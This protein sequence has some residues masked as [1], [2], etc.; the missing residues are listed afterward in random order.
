MIILDAHDGDLG[1]SAWALCARCFHDP[2]VQGGVAIRTREPHWI[3]LA[4][5]QRYHHSCGLALV[6]HG[7]AQI[8]DQPQIQKAAS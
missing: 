2:T 6:D 7:V 3:D 4:T 5:R 8:R 1:M